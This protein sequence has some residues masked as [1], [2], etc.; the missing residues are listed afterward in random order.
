MK[1]ESNRIFRRV[2][3]TFKTQQSQVEQFLKH[4]NASPYK[5]IVTGDF[6]N[7]AYSYIYNKIKGNDLVDTFLEAGNGFGRT[8]D[9]KFLPLRIDFIL[10]DDQFEVN[11]FRTYTDI[12]LSD[13]YPI[14]ATIKLNQ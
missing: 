2:G 13:H 10:A 7:T 11:G 8:Y 14:K 9:F 1:K 6:N 5:T 4:K 3:S 12:K